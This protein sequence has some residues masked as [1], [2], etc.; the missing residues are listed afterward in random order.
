MSCQRDW[1]GPVRKAVWRMWSSSSVLGWRWTAEARSGV[2]VRPLHFV[3]TVL[4]QSINL[5]E[6]FLCPSAVERNN[7]PYPGQWGWPPGCCQGADWDPGRCGSTRWSTWSLRILTSS[8]PTVMAKCANYKHITI[9]TQQYALLNI[10]STS[11]EC[12]GW[13]FE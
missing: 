13:L 4:I 10:Y 9:D 1:C 3:T 11:S 2:T 12:V 8:I 6:I 7:C 5:H